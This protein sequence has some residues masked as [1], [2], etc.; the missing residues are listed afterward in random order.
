MS[1][2]M[3]IAIP[4]I[5]L[6]SSIAH[7]GVTSIL[8]DRD[9]MTSGFF[10][11]D[12][13][14]RGDND[15]RLVNRVSSNSPFGTFNENTYLE[16]NDFYWSSFSAPIDNAVF[17]ISLVSGGFGADSDKSNPFDISMHSLTSDPWTSIDHHATSG[18]GFYQDFVNT[19]ITA[20][21]VVSTITV[22]GNGVYDWDIT[23]LVND[24]ILNGD[25][26]HSFTIA[27]SGILDTSGGTFLQGLVNST[28]PTLTGEETIG[29]IVIVP[30]PPSALLFGAFGMYA[31]RRR[32]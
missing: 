24:W 22:A 5:A 3:K 29:Q 28:S 12:P 18:G 16:F 20:S 8:T 15:G 21:S 23:A 32:R 11:M 2:S 6:A 17:R 19:E 1:I 4:T 30:A 9:Y 25:A 31:I 13:L 14:V 7:A 27:L 26:N 10:S